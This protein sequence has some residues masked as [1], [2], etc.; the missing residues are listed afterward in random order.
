[1]TA[2][3]PIPK[4]KIPVINNKA[5]ILVYFVFALSGVSIILLIFLVIWLINKDKDNVTT[6]INTTNTSTPFGS[7]IVVSTMPISES[8]KIFYLLKTDNINSKIMQ[9]DVRG[10]TSEDVSTVNNFTSIISISPDNNKL[11]VKQEKIN[12]Q[13]EYG[14]WSIYEQKFTIIDVSNLIQANWSSNETINLFFRNNNNKNYEV[15]TYN[16]SANTYTISLSI[17]ANLGERPQISNDLKYLII[18]EP[19]SNLYKFIDLE[20]KMNYSIDSLNLDSGNVFNPLGWTK[21]NQ[22]LYYAQNGVFQLNPQNL[23]SIQLVTLKSKS[24]GFVINNYTYN[25]EKESFLF[26]L[27][28]IVYFYSLKNNTLKEVLNN[29]NSLDKPLLSIIGNGV[30]YFIIENKNGEINNFNIKTSKLSNICDMKCY[31]PLW[32]N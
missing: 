9:Y 6:V 3:N 5:K 8:Y 31:S 7:E 26:T 20:N 19:N 30:N 27:D 13:V 24:E 4:I 18:S 11:F 28:N 15:I 1:M 16:I 32:L 21:E 10:N 14:I 23:K 2:I 12:T 25:F 22:F 29:N 17:P